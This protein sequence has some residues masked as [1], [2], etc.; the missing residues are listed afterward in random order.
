MNTKEAEY[1]KVPNL[2]IVTN[3]KYLVNFILYSI[4]TLQEANRKTSLTII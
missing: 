2:Y 3:S 1:N 4:L